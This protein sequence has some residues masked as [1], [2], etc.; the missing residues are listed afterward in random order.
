MKTMK[1]ILSCLLAISFLFS[2]SCQ[3]SSVE[4]IKVKEEFSQY[5]LI[6]NVALVVE[7]QIVYFNDYELA[8]T[9]WDR[10][11]GFLGVYG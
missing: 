2:C 6:D 4:Y 1:T 11:W 5:N 7:N 9:S 8:L 3:K 10:M